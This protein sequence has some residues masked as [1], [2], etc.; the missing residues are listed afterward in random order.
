M[1]PTLP[2]PKKK[3]ESKESFQG[4]Q[5]TLPLSVQQKGPWIVSTQAN[6]HGKP[7]TCNYSNPWGQRV[8]TAQGRSESTAEL[9][10]GPAVYLWAQKPPSQLLCLA[11]L[12][13]HTEPVLLG[14]CGE[15]RHT[16]QR[17]MSKNSSRVG[18]IFIIIIII[19]LELKCCSSLSDT[20]K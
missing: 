14:L 16:G 11:C 9:R 15:M 18:I 12:T 3:K 10:H 7:R 20:E 2:P 13:A 8:A 6:K 19:I 5:G 1:Q 4:F 17:Q